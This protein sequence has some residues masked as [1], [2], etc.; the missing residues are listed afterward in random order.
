MMWLVKNADIWGFLT[1]YDDILMNNVD[2]LKK[3]P[4]R[5]EQLSMLVYRYLYSPE[6]A[7]KSIDVDILVNELTS[8]LPFSTS[9][10]N[11]NKTNSNVILSSKSIRSIK[12][13]KK[14][15]RKRCPNGTRYN[16]ETGECVPIK[17]NGVKNNKQ[18]EI[19]DLTTPEG[20]ITSVVKKSK[21]II[22]NK[23]RRKRCPNGT[24]YNPNM[25]TCIPINNKSINND[26]NNNNNSS[27]S[28]ES[29]DWFKALRV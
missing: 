13:S 29:Q 18:Y 1:V 6:F 14:T 26:N 12:S 28:T 25:G 7:G 21:V 20:N 11:K 15:R 9:K 4:E 23:T 24:R 10:Q 2:V 5:K 19:I 22:G 16:V 17:K 27:N 3:T 8:I